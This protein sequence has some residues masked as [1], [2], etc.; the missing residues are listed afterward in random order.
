MNVFSGPIMM[1]AISRKLSVR[2][3]GGLAIAGGC[4]LTGIGWI[5][6]VKGAPASTAADHLGPVLP[7]LPLITFYFFNLLP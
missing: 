4:L 7:L 6:L 2:T 3:A 5:A 1:R